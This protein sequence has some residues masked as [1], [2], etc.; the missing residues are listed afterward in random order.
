MKYSSGFWPKPD[1]TFEESEV[2]MLELYCQRAQLE[3]GMKAST[4]GRKGGMGGTCRVWK[5]KT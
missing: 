2:A 5:K 3:D 1:S 4:I